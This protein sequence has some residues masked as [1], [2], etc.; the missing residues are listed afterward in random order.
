MKKRYLVTRLF[1]IMS[2]LEFI[3]SLCYHRIRIRDKFY[4]SIFLLCKEI[5]HIRKERKIAIFIEQFFQWGSS[6]RD[7]SYRFCRN[8]IDIIFCL[9]IHIGKIEILKIL[10]KFCIF[11][12][13]QIVLWFD[14]NINIFLQLIFDNAICDNFG[15]SAQYCLY[16]L[17]I[18]RSIKKFI[19]RRYTSA[20]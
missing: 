9:D 1:L 14:S 2:I 17:I 4:I 10:N 11:K 8:Y 13:T 15:K 7:T 19:T 18:S 12:E 3:D 5:I 20:P 16:L 6:S